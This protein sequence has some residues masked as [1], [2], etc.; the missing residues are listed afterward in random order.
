MD[1][2]ELPRPTSAR[3]SHPTVSERC[4]IAARVDQYME[5]VVAELTECEMEC[6]VAVEQ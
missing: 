5:A 6:V 3:R 4:R 2:K 1:K